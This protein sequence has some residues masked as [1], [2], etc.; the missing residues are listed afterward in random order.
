MTSSS[1]AT[2]AI[3]GAGASTPPALVVPSQAAG[4]SHAFASPASCRGIAVRQSAGN[5]SSLGGGGSSDVAGRA[6]VV[7]AAPD[8]YTSQPSGNAG[9]RIA[10]GVI[11]IID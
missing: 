10:C 4:S 3:S 1:S 8:D 5:R 7:H 9:A 11:T 2:T 6:I